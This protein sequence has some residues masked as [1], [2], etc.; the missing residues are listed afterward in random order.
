MTLKQWTVIIHGMFGF[1]PSLSLMQNVENMLS[2]CRQFILDTPN[3]ASIKW[4]SAFKVNQN[5]GFIAEH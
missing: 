2:Y 1:H 4:E 5:A 3:L